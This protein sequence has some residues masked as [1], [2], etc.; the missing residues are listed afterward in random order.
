MRSSAISKF[1]PLAVLA[2][3]S[4]ASSADSISRPGLK[5]QLDGFLIEW[6]EKNRHVWHT[7]HAT[8]QN[9]W[10]WDAVNTVE[11]IAGYFYCPTARCSTWTIRADAGHLASGTVKSKSSLICVNNVR[12]DSLYAIAMEWILPWDSVEVDRAGKYLVRVTGA[13]A[14]G[15]TLQPMGLTGSAIPLTNKGSGF[16]GRIILITAL[17]IAFIVMQSFRKKTRRRE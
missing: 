13:S 17:V 6:S 10:Y 5:I 7:W 16:A 11:G 12:K 9:E 8:G 3:Y 1:F 15:D 2:V 4:Y 14:C